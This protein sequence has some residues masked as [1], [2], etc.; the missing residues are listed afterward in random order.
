[1]VKYVCEKCNAY[2]P[3]ANDCCPFCEEDHEEEQN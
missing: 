3:K 1:M 2:Y